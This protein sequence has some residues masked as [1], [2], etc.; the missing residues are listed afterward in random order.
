M[1]Q[2]AKIDK[3]IEIPSD[4]GYIKKVSYELLEHLKRYGVDKSVQ[5]DVRLAVEE[6]VRNAIE[7]GNHYNKE[8]PVVIRYIVDSKKITVEI[9]D[10]GEGFHLKNI[11]DP[12]EGDNLLHEGGRGVFLMHKLMDKVVY[13]EKGNIVKIT[14]SF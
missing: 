8:L 13:N 9:E 2:T 1:N 14:K 4:V 10:K 12:S 3:R 5:F 7:H 11:P 6:A